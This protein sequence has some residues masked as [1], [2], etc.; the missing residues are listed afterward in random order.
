MV[1][2]KSQETVER[3]GGEEK[4][5]QGHRMETWGVASACFLTYVNI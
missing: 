3:G 5:S 4:D 1:P 2:G